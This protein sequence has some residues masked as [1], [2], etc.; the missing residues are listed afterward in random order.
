[1]MPGDLPD[2]DLVGDDAVEAFRAGAEAL[3]AAA[4]GDALARVHRTPLGEM[5][6]VV[7]GGFTTL[8]VTVHGWDLAKATGQDPTLA[9]ELAEPLLAFAR[10]AITD[11]NRAPRIGP[12]VATRSASAT[13]RLVAYLGRTP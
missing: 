5:P 12:E 8:D 4:A 3:L 6:G 7:L 2:R 11:A 9:P 13:D 1:M 10:E